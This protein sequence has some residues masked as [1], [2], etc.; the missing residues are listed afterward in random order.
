MLKNGFVEV[1]YV[2][3]C[4]RYSGG[5]DSSVERIYPWY[6]V[7]IR[8]RQSKIEIPPSS[9]LMGTTSLLVSL[10]N[11]YQGWTHSTHASRTID[12]NPNF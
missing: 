5:G 10:F 6:R 11:C 3:G 9:F 12:W 2:C 7:W 4:R 1:S 8:K